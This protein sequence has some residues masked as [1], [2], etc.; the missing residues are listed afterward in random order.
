M[1]LQQLEQLADQY[2][3]LL[4][5]FCLRLTGHRENGE[6]LCQ[7]AFLKAVELRERIDVQR[8]PKSFLFAL[9]VGIW[10]N[11]KRKL[12]RRQSILPMAYPAAEEIIQKAVSREQQPEEQILQQ[13]L[14]CQVS[15]TVQGLKEKYRLPVLMHYTAG[16]SIEEIGK[17]LKIPPGTVKSR[18]YYARKIIK[19]ELEVKGYGTEE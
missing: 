7:Q 10:K 19:K 3:S 13:A 4:Y 11:E 15:Q 6:D 9:A 8:S 18:L 17:I 2:G 5:S 12:W 1:E 16:F 14:C